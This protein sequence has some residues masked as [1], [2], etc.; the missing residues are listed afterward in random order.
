[1]ALTIDNPDA[2]VYSDEKM[3]A[4]CQDAVAALGTGASYAIVGSRSYT[5]HNLNDLLEL[6]SFYENRVM[7][8]KGAIGQ[9]LADFS[10]AG[11]S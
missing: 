10:D 8:Q 5:S 4:L 2:T 9:N 1:M 3:Y 7:A 11:G 6:L